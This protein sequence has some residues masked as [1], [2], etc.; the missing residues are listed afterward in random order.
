M[1]NTYYYE[2]PYEDT[3]VTTTTTT[4]ASPRRNNLTIILLIALGIFLLIVLFFLL[5]TRPGSNTTNPPPSNQKIVLQFRGAFIDKDVI[6]PLLDDYNAKNPNVTIEYANRWPGG[7]YSEAEKLYRSELNK[8]FKDD[9]SV[10]IPDIFMVHNSWAGDYD[11]KYTKPSTN[12]D[13]ETFKST[14]YPAVADDF[15]HDNIVHGVPLWMDTLAIAYNKDLL[16]EKTFGAPLKTWTEFKNQAIVLTK[17]ENNNITQAG[18]A[19]GVPGNASFQ[20]QLANVLLMQNGVQILDSTGKPTFSTDSDTSV[21]LNFFKSFANS[22]GTWDANFK[23]D[24]ASFLEGD[25]AMILTTSYRLRDLIK[26]N[27]VYDLKINMGISQLPQLA[28]QS[29]PIINF[30]DYWGAMVAL[31]RPNSA[32][33]WDFLKWL[34]EPDQLKKL[35]DNVANSSQSFGL[36]YP[37]KDMAQ[38]RQND[39]DLQVFNESL[40]Y[41]KSWYMVKGI[42][43]KDEFLTLLGNTTITTSDIAVTE[44]N[45]QTHITNRGK[46]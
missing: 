10:K 31:N 17:R 41:A 19:A 26:Y 44:N 8:L 46:L 18:F 25:T 9:E 29:E 15:A 11:G 2:Q 33:A 27:K 13:A 7:K 42:E 5:F 45:I 21:A 37:R 3:A 16:A 28:G 40:P 12:Y 1:A 24:A 32:A 43:V 6:Q 23:A 39:P 4:T 14:F 36:L 35:S 38:L 30:A 34:T 22:G 20:F